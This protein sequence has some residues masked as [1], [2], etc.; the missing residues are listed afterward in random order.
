MGSFFAQF[1]ALCRKNWY[2]QSTIITVFTGLT[3]RI[4]LWKHKWIN[5]VR[6][7]LLP[8]AYSVF[9]AEAI[10][11]LIPFTCT[12]LITRTS[13][14]QL[15][16]Y[17][18]LLWR[19][20]NANKQLGPG[21]IRPLQSIPTTLLERK[22][23]WSPPAAAL[24]NTTLNEFVNTLISRSFEGV[25][26]P[27]I[28]IENPDDLTEQCPSNFA[29]LSTCFAAVNFGTVDPGSQTLVY[30]SHMLYGDKG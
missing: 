8:I 20:G 30:P 22:F 7:L 18:D 14:P 9:F 16:S 15:V 11:R 12:V 6:C 26:A 27:V 21:Q 19:F 23:V 1:S 28:R 3:P 29:S 13:L 24:T 4:I 2:V 10:V 25:T 17:V 5:I